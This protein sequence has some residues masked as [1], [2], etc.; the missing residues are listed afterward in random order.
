MKL[1]TQ[2]TIHQIVE[3][4]KQDSE[5]PFDLHDEMDDIIGYYQIEDLNETDAK[6]ILHQEINNIAERAQ[7]REIVRQTAEIWGW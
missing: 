3:Y 5:F 4:I 7:T 2:L 6:D 1:E